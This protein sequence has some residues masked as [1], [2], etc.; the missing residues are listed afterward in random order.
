M[1]GT[2]PIATSTYVELWKDGGWTRW[3]ATFSS[4]EQLLAWLEQR[5]AGLDVLDRS[6]VNADPVYA[7][8]E[9]DLRE[10]V[11]VIETFPR[12]GPLTEGQE[13]LMEYFNPTCEHGLSAQLCYGPMH[14]SDEF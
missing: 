6:R 1:A 8:D 3:Y 12:V 11:V 14:Y 10:G 7:E 13:A 2:A 4:P 9:R 5:N